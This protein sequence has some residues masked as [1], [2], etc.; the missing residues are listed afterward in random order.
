V[1]NP[2]QEENEMGTIRVL[3]K[4]GDQPTG[5]TVDDYSDAEKIF[6]NLTR[7]GWSGFEKNGNDLKKISRFNPES[8]E[9]VMVP[10][11]LGG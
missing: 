6:K 10:R 1:T 4:R 9:T 7:T 2:E 8:E 11:I 3:C 5:Y